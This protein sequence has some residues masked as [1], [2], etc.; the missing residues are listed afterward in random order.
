MPSRWRPFGA[1]ADLDLDFAAR[2]RPGL[3][4]RL[5][6]ACCEEV[7]EA[8]AV[9]SLTLA[10]RIA[11][12]AS[13][14]S[15]SES[16]DAL[17]LPLRCPSCRDALEVILPHAFL[18]DEANRGAQ[19]RSVEVEL[20]AAGRVELRRPTG[21]D[22]R[23]WRALRHA[24]AD[25]AVAAIVASLAP[26]ARQFSASGLRAMSEAMEAF[27]PLAA[28]QITT[29]CPACGLPSTLPVDLEAV[30]VARL[31]RHQRRVLEQVHRLAGFYGW[32]E[33]EVLAVP[34]WRREEYLGLIERGAAQ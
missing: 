11:A 20:E 3:V 1:R 10:E 26:R 24:G 16:T 12:L 28:F 17:A 4:T 25:E 14:V 7:C 22:Q 15:L 13:I 8:D 29:T 31:E 33:E 5:L 19:V 9:W 34:A 32:T 21:A 2:D 27:D 18:L 6:C 30:L 23:A